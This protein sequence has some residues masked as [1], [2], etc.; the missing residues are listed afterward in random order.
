MALVKFLINIISIPISM[1]MIIGWILWSIL[2]S[3]WGVI[4]ISIFAKEKY[5]GIYK[6]YTLW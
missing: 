2:W 1:F 5:N 6:M 4:I 3:I